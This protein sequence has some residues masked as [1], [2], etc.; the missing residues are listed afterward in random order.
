MQ[1]DVI[2]GVQCNVVVPVV[3]VIVVVVVVQWQWQLSIYLFLYKLENETIL[4]D[5]LNVSSWQRQK[6]SNS[7][8]LP[9]YPKFSKLTKS[10]TKRTRHASFQILFKCP[11]LPSFLDMLQIPHVLLTFGKVQNPPRLPRKTTSEPSKVVR[12]C[13]VFFAPQRRALFRHV[14][15]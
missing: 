13:R 11:H 7:A 5:F 3:V 12:A 2:S 10:K 9:Q 4:R 1:S 6:R 14:N 8:R 15:F